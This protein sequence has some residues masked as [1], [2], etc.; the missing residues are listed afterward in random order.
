M[1]EKPKNIRWRAI[2]K[3]KHLAD[4]FYLKDENLGA[5]VRKNGLHLSDLKSWQ[6]E[7]YQ[8][9]DGAKPMRN[10]EKKRLEIK[11]KFLEK[12]LEKANLKIELQ[13]K[14]QEIL[15]PK[16]GAESLTS[17]KEESSST[18]LENLEEED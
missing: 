13:K 17:S 8:A 18:S 14:A 9:F 10:E 15:N 5:Y 2:H 6:D 7:A 1:S 4:S 12:Q 11:I 3:L 16:S